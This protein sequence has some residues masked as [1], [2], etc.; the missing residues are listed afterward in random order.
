MFP[1]TD[2]PCRSFYEA[3]DRY[4]GLSDLSRSSVGI[5][6]L[7]SSKKQFVQQW[8]EYRLCFGPPVSFLEAVVV[9]SHEVCALEHVMSIMHNWRFGHGQLKHLGYLHD[10]VQC[11]EE[12]PTGIGCRRYFLRLLH[13]MGVYADSRCFNWQNIH[14]VHARCC[15]VYSKATGRHTSWCAFFANEEITV[16]QLEEV[17]EYR[18]KMRGLVIE[19]KNV[20]ENAEITAKQRLD[21]SDAL[22]HEQQMV[23]AWREDRDYPM[24]TY[25]PPRLPDSRKPSSVGTRQPSSVHGTT[26]PK[27]TPDPAVVWDHLIHPSRRAR[28]AEIR[29]ARPAASSNQPTSTSREYDS[30][31]A[32]R[33]RLLAD[34]SLRGTTRLPRYERYFWQYN[35]GRYNDGYVRWTSQAA[36]WSR[37]DYGVNKAAEHE[38]THE[39]GGTQR[40]KDF[41]DRLVEIQE[42]A[43]RINDTTNRKA[44]TLAIKWIFSRLRSAAELSMSEEENDEEFVNRWDDEHFQNDADAYLRSLANMDGKLLATDYTVVDLQN[45]GKILMAV[46]YDGTYSRTEPLPAQFSTLV[47]TSQAPPPPPWRDDNVFHLTVEKRNRVCTGSG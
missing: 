8:T 45:I 38:E 29:A 35:A 33:R 28:I 31:G 41:D 37:A 46:I 22:R 14:Q 25:W 19:A 36:L 1:P 27:P 7:Y 24:Q 6:K 12:M 26:G 18:R 16:E 32:K 43:F 21:Y 3:L 2:Y 34:D 10:F 11:L 20:Q 5:E 39:R 13:R 17:T 42:E 47:D 23:S 4:Y 15:G 9:D 30:T 40:E 44:Y